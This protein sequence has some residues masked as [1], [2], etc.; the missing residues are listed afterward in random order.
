MKNTTFLFFC[1]T[2]LLSSCGCCLQVA[3]GT[4]MDSKTKQPIANV[5]IIR[6][7]KEMEQTDATGYFNLTG[8][9][10]GITCPLMKVRFES[11]GYTTTE[12]TLEGDGN[13]IYLNPIK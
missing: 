4:V 10:G 13:E 11:E 12:K 3:S 7:E 9:S 5:N 6:E 1:L 2:L 8:V